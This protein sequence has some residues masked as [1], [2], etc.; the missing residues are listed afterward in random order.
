MVDLVFR[1]SSVTRSKEQ[2]QFAESVAI[3]E[4]PSRHIDHRP[5]CRQ[6]GD[7]AA[8]VVQGSLELW[9]R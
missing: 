1:A 5:G 4:G 8:G 6:E 7:M 2:P 9:E 3:K